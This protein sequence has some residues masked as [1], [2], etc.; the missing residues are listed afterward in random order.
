[1]SLI[2]SKTTMFSTLDFLSLLSISLSVSFS[3][4]CF[5]HF[6]STSC[7][8]PR[9]S[10][11]LSLPMCGLVK[12][13]FSCIF[14]LY[15]EICCKF[16]TLSSFTRFLS[17]VF[18]YHPFLP[19]IFALFWHP[20]VGCFPLDLSSVINHCHPTSRKGKPAAPS[21]LN[22]SAHFQAVNA[23]VCVCVLYLCA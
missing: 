17:C 14:I 6:I 9:V 23:C 20:V 3:C 10:Y 5:F 13:K 8:D 22:T 7:V 16:S 1:M 18:L 11:I 15:Q 12:G 2:D 19:L 21:S 4:V